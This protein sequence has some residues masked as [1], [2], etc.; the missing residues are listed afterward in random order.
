[1]EPVLQD[2]HS[3]EKSRP[4]QTVIERI[5][6]AM[7]KKLSAVATPMTEA[8]LRKE[9]PGR[10]QYKTSALR[11]LVTDKKVLRI[12]SGAKGDAFRYSA[13]SLRKAIKQEFEEIIL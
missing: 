12:G 11:L 13:Q 2:A 4:H 5:S 6:N 7:L 8:V 3:Q 1:M 9:I 10:K